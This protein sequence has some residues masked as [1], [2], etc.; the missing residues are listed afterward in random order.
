MALKIRLNK[1]QQFILQDKLT[2]NEFYTKKKLYLFIFDIFS[3]HVEFDTPAAHQRLI[4]LWGQAAV[5]INKYTQPTESF[6]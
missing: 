3:D 6:I 4:L 2:F 5:H 1:Q